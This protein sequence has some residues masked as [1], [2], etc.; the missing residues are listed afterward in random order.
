VDDIVE[1]ARG[2]RKNAKAANAAL[3]FGANFF[4]RVNAEAL[5]HIDAWVPD[6]LPRAARQATGAWRVSSA[7]LGRSFEEDLSI[8]PGGIQDFG[9]ETSLTPIDLVMQYGGAGDAATAALWLCDRMDIVPATIGW[10][11]SNTK[12]GCSPLGALP[13]SE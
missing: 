5:A 10:R 6:L 1:R 2:D 13:K 4:Q 12:L 8:H 11:S 7:D 3:D 9:P